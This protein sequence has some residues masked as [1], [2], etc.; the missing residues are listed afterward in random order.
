M[1]Q[2][3]KTRAIIKDRKAHLEK[4]L[5]D[6]KGD[7]KGVSEKQ[8]NE[9]V[10]KFQDHLNEWIEL[11]TIIKSDF[12]EAQ[13]NKV[14]EVTLIPTRNFMEHEKKEISSVFEL[15]KKV[16]NLSS[17]TRKYMNNEVAI[18]NKKISVINEAITELKNK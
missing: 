4:V 2:Y 8:N 16:N 9:N 3:P 12:T 7:V 1:K 10:K 17:K 15:N 18:K 14:L 6:L 11:E 13:L 5:K